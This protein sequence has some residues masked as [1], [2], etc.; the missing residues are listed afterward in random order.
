MSTL[1]GEFS[2]RPA[3]EKRQL[4]CRHHWYTPRLGTRT[5]SASLAAS[6]GH[7]TRAP[8]KPPQRLIHSS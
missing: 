5:W 2:E 1:G 7:A 4:R 6:C 8:P 3:P